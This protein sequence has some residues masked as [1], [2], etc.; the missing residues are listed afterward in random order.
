MNI[1]ENSNSEDNR[2]S[3]VTPP[4]TFQETSRTVLNKRG[5]TLLELILVCL[6][7]GIL[8]AMALPSFTSYKES[9]RSA[10]AA[11]ELRS[12]E[13]AITSFYNDRNRYPADLSEVGYDTLRDPWNNPYHF[14]NIPT[15]HFVSEYNVDYDLWSS[16]I[17]GRSDLSGSIVGPDS[18]DDIIRFGS[19]SFCGL[20]VAYAT[21]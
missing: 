18:L 4:L 1:L 2:A 12:M 3:A 13:T 19:G 14:S 16:G 11:T 9:A 5:F 21:P 20:A 8:V 7:L 15:L 10:R 6:V 17:N